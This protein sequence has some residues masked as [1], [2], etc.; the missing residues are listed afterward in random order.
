MP[1][2]L[3]FNEIVTKG[4]RS[5]RKAPGM[6]DARAQPAPREASMLW[7]ENGCRETTRA[8]RRAQSRRDTWR[9]ALVIWAALVLQAL[10]QALGLHLF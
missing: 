4:P 5:R 8:E 9:M 10:I 3:I 7:I 1:N 2:V 6:V